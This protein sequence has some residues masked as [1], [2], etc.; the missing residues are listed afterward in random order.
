ML[1]NIGLPIDKEYF[2]FQ[3]QKLFV[4]NRDWLKVSNKLS[5]DRHLSISC[6]KKKHGETFHLFNELNS[7]PELGIAP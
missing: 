2:V 6:Q 4:R 1:T 7:D 5:F 3:H